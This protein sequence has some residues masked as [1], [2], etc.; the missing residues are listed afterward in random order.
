MINIAILNFIGMS[1]NRI[2]EKLIFICFR[3]IEMISF[4]LT[5]ELFKNS[6]KL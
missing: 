4:R 3:F 1:K 5:I 2:V 6:N